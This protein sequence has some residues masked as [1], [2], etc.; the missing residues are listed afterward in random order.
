MLPADSLE[1]A[2]GSA[3]PLQAPG[4]QHFYDPGRR[5]ARAVARSLGGKGKIA[6]DMYLLY[7][8]LAAW[9]R[10]PPAPL[11]WVHQLDD[12]LWADASRHRSGAA[13]AEELESMIYA[14]V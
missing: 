4:V 1:A 12:A 10:L 14:A 7:E 2:R 8:P 13:L 5:I 9:R 11:D 6:W 3:R